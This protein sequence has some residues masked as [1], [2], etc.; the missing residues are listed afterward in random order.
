MK[1]YYGIVHKDDDSAYGISFPDLP[2]C[3]S[4]ADR[5]DDIVGKA[6]EALTLWFE[7]QPEVEP[8]PLSRVVE[9]AGQDL[10]EGAFLVRVPWIGMAGKLVRTNVSLDRAMLEAIDQAAASRNM[11]RSG[12]LV[13]AARREIEAQ[14]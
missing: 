3:F 1:Y 12:F 4:A 5:E 11:T 2:G 10:G 14:S 6:V 13:E 8:S 7:D 9:L